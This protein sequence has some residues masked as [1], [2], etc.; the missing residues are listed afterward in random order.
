MHDIISHIE[1]AQVLAPQTIQAAALNS[2]DIDTQGCGTLAVA[3][4]VGNIADTLDGS[5]RIDVKI[6]HA[7]DDGTGNPGAYGACSDEDV[8]N[9]ANLASGVF[10]KI[11]A[12][13][14]ENARHVVGYRGGKRFVKVT[15]TPVS[16]ET[17]GPVAML[18]LK[19][20]AAQKPVDNG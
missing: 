16:I 2:G 5:N 13:G 11:D 14:K 10:L 20:A 18:A 19:G 4:L 3:L 9:F 12:A 17:G 8:L 7:D 1:T 15:A 6:E